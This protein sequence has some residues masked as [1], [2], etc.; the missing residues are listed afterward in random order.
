M[1]SLIICLNIFLWEK[2]YEKFYIYIF[3]WKYVN[4]LHFYKINAIYL[5]MFRLH[6]SYIYI[7]S[8]YV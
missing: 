1:K 6:N 2:S 3:R 7:K 4:T 8:S 5:T